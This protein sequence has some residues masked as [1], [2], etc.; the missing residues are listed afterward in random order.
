M[1]E[2]ASFQAWKI[3]EW[4]EKLQTIKNISLNVNRKLKLSYV[5]FKADGCLILEV[6]KLWGFDS[7]IEIFT[8]EYYKRSK[9]LISV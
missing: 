4:D 6:H 5:K 8:Y 1:I 3:L 9:N 7:L 2:I